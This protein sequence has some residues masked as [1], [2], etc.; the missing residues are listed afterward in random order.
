VFLFSLPPLLLP[1]TGCEEFSRFVQGGGLGL[2]STSL[3]ALAGGTRSGEGTSFRTPARGSFPPS[4]FPQ[5][6][7]NR[8]PGNFGRPTSRSGGGLSLSDSLGGSAE[9]VLNLPIMKQSSGGS[10]A[11]KRGC[12]PTSLLMATGRS[13]PREIQDVLVQTCDRPGGLVASRAVNWLRAN[14]YR[15]AEHFGDWTVDQLRTE[16][17]ERKNPVLVNF[18]NPNSGNGHIVVVTGVTDQGVHINDPG[19]G[20]RRVLPVRQFERQWAG[21]DEWAIPVRAA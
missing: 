14:G 17:M 12:G 21:R 11:A 15:G 9:G 3:T 8:R 20:T 6:S 5:R 16:T 18:V 10:E 1:L 19:P 7:S 4:L 13:D 2:I